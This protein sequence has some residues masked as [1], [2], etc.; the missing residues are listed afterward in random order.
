MD[1]YGQPRHMKMSEIDNMD[2]PKEDPE[3]EGSGAGL[4]W[5]DDV[6]NLNLPSRTFYKES[7]PKINDSEREDPFSFTTNPHSHLRNDHPDRAHNKKDD[8]DQIKASRMQSELNRKNKN[9]GNSQILIIII[10]QRRI[11]FFVVN[12]G[13]QLDNIHQF[14]HQG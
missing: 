14:H 2:P 4:S 6:D 13:I 11:Q 10:Y 3:P 5:L 1:Y 7:K 12:Y 8:F 9:L